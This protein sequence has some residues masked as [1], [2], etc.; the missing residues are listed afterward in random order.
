MKPDK[1]ESIQN[2]STKDISVCLEEDFVVCTLP[3]DFFEKVMDLENSLLVNIDVQVVETLASMY[4]KAVQFYSSRNRQKE[5]D[6]LYRLKVLLSNEDIMK[7]LNK[8]RLK[9]KLSHMSPPGL[10]SKSIL[11]E[12]KNSYQTSVEVIMEDMQIQK[13]SLLRNR[14]NKKRI[15]LIS[16]DAVKSF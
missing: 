8:V 3:K 11:L 9:E 13:K 1:M 12:F 16:T 4:Q 2:V 15:S 5:L 6:Y 7:Q 14:L 10:S